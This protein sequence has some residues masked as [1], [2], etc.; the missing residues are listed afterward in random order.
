MVWDFCIAGLLWLHQIQSLVGNQSKRHKDSDVT[1]ENR[2]SCLL[3]SRNDLNA[4]L[5]LD[6]KDLWI[7]FEQLFFIIIILTSHG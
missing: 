1:T 6:I 5:V 7:P 4:L 3:Y 2:A